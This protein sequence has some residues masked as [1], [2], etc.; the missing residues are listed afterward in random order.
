MHDAP[1]IFG[2]FE[3]RKDNVE[4]PVV[5]LLVVCDISGSMAGRKIEMLKKVKELD[6]FDVVEHAQVPGAPLF[7]CSSIN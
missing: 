2:N 6:F 4:R 5:D 1:Q 7:A 3:E